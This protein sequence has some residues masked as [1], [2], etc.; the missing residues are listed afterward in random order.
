MSKFRPDTSYRVR[1]IPRAYSS[2]EVEASLAKA[3]DCA[4]K[5]KPVLMSLAASVY[6]ESQDATVCFDCLPSSLLSEKLPKT[7]QMLDIP[8]KEG[9]DSGNDRPFHSPVNITMDVDYL[10]M[11]TLKSYLEKEHKFK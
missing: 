3:F 11:T 10:G 9:F 4:A 7:F 2:T 5:T 8:N 1:G 6:G